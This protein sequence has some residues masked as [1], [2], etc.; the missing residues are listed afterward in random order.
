M[1]FV[2]G[3]D[4][5]RSGWVAFKVELPSLVTSVELV[6]LPLILRNKPTD[7]ACLGIDI[8]IGLLNGSRACDRAARKLLG[9]PR[10]TSVFAAPCRAALAAKNHADASAINLRVT[11]SESRCKLG[12]IM[13]KTVRIRRYTVAVNS[14]FAPCRFMHSNGT[15]VPTNLMTLA[16]C[17]AAMRRVVQVGEWVAG[18]TPKRMTMPSKLAF[19]LKVDGEY[20]REEYWDKYEGSRLD[21]IYR[22]NPKA[23]FD[24]EQLPNPWHGADEQALDM[25]CHRI[26][27]S[28]NFYWFAQSYT[29]RTKAPQGLPLPPEYGKLALSQRSMFGVFC[30]LPE[31]FLQWVSERPQLDSFIVLD[32]NKSLETLPDCPRT[33]C[34]RAS[35]IATAP[36]REAS[37]VQAHS[38]H[39]DC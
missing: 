26:L 11:G 6:D 15:Y 4:G 19:L 23:K 31:S 38:T 35:P 8:P 39:G 16:N 2:A 14:G 20:T 37:C 12:V 17:M 18:V 25:K 36:K 21:C 7:L 24:F 27:R 10:G 9:Q 3:V 33:S 30:E 32:G 5:C 28:T 13:S 22:P 34:V 1:P 29:R